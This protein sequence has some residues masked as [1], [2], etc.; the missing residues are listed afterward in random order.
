MPITLIET[1]EF[2]RFPAL[3]NTDRNYDYLE[4]DL[5]IMSD[6]P[7]VSSGWT[8]GRLPINYPI[9]MGCILVI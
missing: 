9:K 6:R 4:K 5:G 8:S 7:L 2:F 1:T 3:I